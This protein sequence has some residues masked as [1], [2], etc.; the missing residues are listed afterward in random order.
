[1]RLAKR[2][3]LASHAQRIVEVLESHPG[4]QYDRVL[5]EILQQKPP[6][7]DPRLRGDVLLTGEEEAQPLREFFRAP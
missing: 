2:H 7:L 1:V 6:G 4:G 5:D 3:L